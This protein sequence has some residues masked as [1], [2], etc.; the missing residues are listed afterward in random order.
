MGLLPVKNGVYV[1]SWVDNGQK[2]HQCA[3]CNPRR[4]RCPSTPSC[5][6][7]SGPPVCG[8]WR[9]ASA[10]SG[11]RGRAEM[12]VQK[13]YLGNAALALLYSAENGLGCV[14]PDMHDIAK[15]EI[16]LHI[17]RC[18]AEGR[19]RVTFDLLPDKPSSAPTRK[20]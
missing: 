6:P 11:A 12:K 17:K 15:A 13:Q 8:A 20:G 4:T 1:H 9:M 19:K 5:S 10:S 18:L 14:D 16:A 7:S 3:S 2:L